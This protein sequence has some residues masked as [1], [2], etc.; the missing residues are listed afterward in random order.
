M[1]NLN[2]SYLNDQNKVLV[3]VSEL[4]LGMYICEL[5]K[6]WRDSSFLFQGFLL[7]N[8]VIL[9]KVRDECEY[10]YIDVARQSSG[11]AVSFTTDVYTDKARNTSGLRLKKAV[12]KK[13]NSFYKK[14][15]FLKAFKIKNKF[16]K[17]P[18]KNNLA[19]ILKSNINPEEIIPPEKTHSFEQE[20]DDAQQAHSHT[21]QVIQDFM[22]EVEKGGAIDMQIAN[23]A[24]KDCMHSVLRTPDAMMLMTHLKSKDN[25]TWRHSMNTCV[26]AI[27]LGRYLNLK[28]EELVTLGL[29]AVLHDIGK[30]LI[31]DWILSKSTGLNREEIEIL[32]S[33]TTLGKNILTSSPKNE[34][35]ISEILNKSTELDSEEI[36]TMKFHA[37]LTQSILTSCSTKMTSIISNVAHMHHEQ[38]D[39]KGY[40][41]GLMSNQISPYAKMIA[42]VDAYDSLI[43][44]KPYQPGQTHFG[45][46]DILLN[47]AKSYYDE[48]LVNCFIRTL[49]TYPAGSAVEMNTG[50]IGMVIEVNQQKKLRPKIILLSDMDKRPQPEKMVDLAE[51]YQDAC[52]NP[53]AIKTIIRP[54]AYDIDINQYYNYGIIQQRLGAAA[55]A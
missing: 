29:C 50:E 51:T 34:G 38:L 39:G 26:L 20:I 19:D 40:P 17:K 1:K 55:A 52:G 42:I 9:Q 13:Q 46:V 36:E 2:T 37:S 43:T 25:N 7:Q 10:V 32:Q 53:Y 28:D 33:H 31:P 44:G 15:G 27:S 3:E 45:A 4:T 47:R 14:S 12:V 11:Q 21:G 5:D 48:T 16:E 49:G 6:P 8:Q 24:V 30:L 23:K 54:D 22:G 35:M 41:N 18:N